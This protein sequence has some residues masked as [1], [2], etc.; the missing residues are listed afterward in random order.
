MELRKRIYAAAV[1]SL[2]LIPAAITISGCGS[3][4]AHEDPV[5]TKKRMAA[6]TG[7]RSYFD[8]SQGNYDALSPEDKS[9]LNAIT[10]SEQKS[11]EA[12]GHIPNTGAGSGLPAHGPNNH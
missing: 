1:L 3:G 7:I 4:V 10:G 6:A 11:R 12:F 2:L 5:V 8:K 9:A